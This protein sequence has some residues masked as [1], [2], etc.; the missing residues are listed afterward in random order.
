MDLR[1]EIALMRK[2]LSIEIDG[3]VQNTINKQQNKFLEQSNK[4]YS[5]IISDL[6]NNF[7]TYIKEMNNEV[8]E[9]KKEIM[10][11]GNQNSDFNSKILGF[12]NEIQEFKSVLSKI[13]IVLDKDR[14]LMNPL[15]KNIVNLELDLNKIND[16]IKNKSSL[17]E[18]NLIELNKKISNFDRTIQNKN[19]NLLENINHYPDIKNY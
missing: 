11:I 9:L 16:K 12:N 6:R 15:S 7:A 1:T 8:I 18:N 5:T 4:L 3:M 14:N 10:N 19:T 17:I 13:D 2:N